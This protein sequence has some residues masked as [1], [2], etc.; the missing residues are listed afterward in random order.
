VKR[1][2]SASRAAL[3]AVFLVGSVPASAQELEPGAYWALPTGVNIMSI[4]NVF[5]AGDVWFDPSIPVEEADSTFNATTAVWTGY[6]GL[7]GRT[8]NVSVQVPVVAGHLEGTFGGVREEETR[9]GLADPRV[10]FAMNFRGAPAM[11][12]RDFD[13]YRQGAII[14]ASVAA[15]LPLG[16]YDGDRYINIGSNRWAFKPEIGVSYAMGRWILDGMAGAWFMTE[17]GHAPQGPRTQ[18]PILSTQVHLTC[19]FRT[20]MWLAGDAN[21][22]YGGRVSVNG[23]PNTANFRNARVGTT[24]SIALTRR[25]AI[26]ASI[27]GGAV[28]SIGGDFLATAFGYNYAF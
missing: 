12:Q 19:R 21:F 15:V 25:H 3:L 27:S 5:S 14:G 4:I 8:A 10:R 26:R 18:A 1:H 20:N 17:N 11:S 6:F 23:E 22:Y 9:F 7:A 16:Q 28:T 13:K 24:L 2:S